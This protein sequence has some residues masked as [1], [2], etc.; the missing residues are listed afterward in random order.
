LNENLSF[1][2]CKINATRASPESY[3]STA[4]KIDTIIISKLQENLL[5]KC[6]NVLNPCGKIIIYANEEEISILQQSKDFT[7]LNIFK[8]SEIPNIS[9]IDPA[10]RSELRNYNIVIV[11]LPS[12]IK[13]EF[14]FVVGLMGSG[15]SRF[16]NQIRNY[17]HPPTEL[18]IINTDESV[19]QY[20]KYQL[21][22]ND[23]VYSEIRKDLDPKNDALIDKLLGE[24]KCIVLETTKINA[25]YAEQLKKTHKVISIICNTTVDQIKSNIE[26]RNV[27]NIRKTTFNSGQFREFQSN[28]EKYKNYVDELYEF[29]MITAKFIKL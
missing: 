11:C 13:P 15:K 27:F 20:I 28:T 8:M 5:A 21:Y 19:L 7:I 9:I 16:I 6:K 14:I 4:E 17:I 1:N 23:A 22:H 18:N 24:K 26:K 3:L 12:N 2:E 29:D 25:D 10:I